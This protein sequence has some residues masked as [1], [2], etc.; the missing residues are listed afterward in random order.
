MLRLHRAGLGYSSVSWSEFADHVA[1]QRPDAVTV[2]VFETCVV[3]DLA[4]DQAIEVVAS[5]WA[6]QGNSGGA[7]HVSDHAEAAAKLELE[8][9]QP[10]PGAVDALDRIRATVGHIVFI[11]DTDRSSSLLIEMLQQHGL[12]REGDRL[13]ASCEEGITKSRGG[14]YNLIWSTRPETVWHLGNNDWA[15][16]VM[17][18]AHGYEPFDIPAG[19]L[20][21]YEAAMCREP[22]GMGPVLAGAARSTRLQLNYEFE[23]GKLDERSYYLNRLGAQ[24]AGPT[25]AAFA[26]WIADQVRRHNIDHLGFLARDGELPKLVCDRMPHSGLQATN[27]SYVHLN[28]LVVTLATAPVIGAEA[29]IDEGTRDETD[30][31]RIRMHTVAFSDLLRRV[32]FEP[33]DVAR[34][35]GASSVLASHD[36]TLPL[37]P[38]QTDAWLAMLGDQGVREL[39]LERATERR[40]AMVE[41]LAQLG[42]LAS[43]QPAF[44]DVGWRGRLARLTNTALRDCFDNE[45]I[46]LHFGGDRVPPDVDEQARIHR[47]AFPGTTQI[48]P[49]DNPPGPVETITASGNLRVSGYQKTPSGEVEPIF[50]AETTNVGQSDRAEL[51][52]GAIAMIDRLPDADS[53]ASWD[54]TE[55]TL[56]SDAREILRLWWYE[57]DGDEAQAMTSFAFEGDEAGAEVR[58]VL[59]PYA[60]SDIVGQNRVPRQWRQGSGAISP[61]ASRVGLAAAMVARRA[62]GAIKRG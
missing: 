20:S 45:P 27:R 33:D 17:A 51:W 42:L 16:G 6:E 7:G 59:A 58:P 1:R 12:F 10:V 43:T 61:V 9:C 52:R 19:N 47:F 4:G 29:W 13:V 35:L 34:V 24:V 11:S 26:L 39:I 53:I 8:L 41:Y 25:M 14:L 54:L 50:E 38:S 49:F 31:L 48:E 30:F 28:R 46:H 40:S 23:R 62:L 18:A 57:P 3:R 60:L 36:P 15:D 56:D 5:R 55:A 22:G 32:G 37:Q 2:D 21:R 44:V